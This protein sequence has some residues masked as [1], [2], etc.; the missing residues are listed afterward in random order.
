MSFLLS[1]SGCEQNNIREYNKTK[2]VSIVL[3][4]VESSEA[5]AD[6]IVKLQSDLLQTPN[7]NAKVLSHGALNSTTYGIDLKV[8]CAQ[9]APFIALLEKHTK[10]YSSDKAI[11]RPISDFKPGVPFG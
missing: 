8:D 9:S 7:L 2:T 1:V 5:I 3:V 11:C 4:K 10:L 6:V